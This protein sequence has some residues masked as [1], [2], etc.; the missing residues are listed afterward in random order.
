VA[1]T[2][3]ITGATRGIGRSTALALAAR[4]FQL[5][6]VGRSTE[7][8]PNRAGLPGTLEDVAAQAEKAGAA[9]LPLAQDLASDGAPQRVAVQML[10]RFGR[11]D[12]LVN[13]AAVSF[14]GPF[15]QVPG[16]RWKTVMT[17]NLFAS[18]ELIEALLPGMIERGDG[19]I[20]NMGSDAADTR[21]RSE[22]PQLPYA[23]SKAAIEAM[24][25]GLA[26][27]LAGTGVAVNAVRP[28]VATEAVTF[29]AP[30]LLDDPSGRWADVTAYGE[31]MAWLVQQPAEFTGHLL[32]ND[33]LT[34]AGA[35]AR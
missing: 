21:G 19:R 4:G 11:C 9:V 8:R 2:A 20:V 12:V 28:V 5:A 13:N 1:R 10:G 25:S 35:L 34:A 31:A 32:S 17:V 14:I 7:E 27:Q 29:S 23:A 33:D 30:H 22:V 3:L 24:S 6:L 26:A 18:V 16:R 15:T